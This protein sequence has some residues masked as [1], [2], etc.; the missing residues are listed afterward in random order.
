MI[1]TY[2]IQRVECTLALLVFK[3]YL[4]WISHVIGKAYNFLFLWGLQ[5]TFVMLKS[6]WNIASGGWKTLFAYKIKR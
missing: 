2:F 4:F 6:A 3:A 1:L 5:Q